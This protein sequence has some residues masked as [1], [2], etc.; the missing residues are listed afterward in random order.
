MSSIRFSKVKLGEPSQDV[1][2]DLDML[3]ADH[4]VL[5]TS[6]QLGT[7]Y[8]DFFSRSSGLAPQLNTF[9]HV[10]PTSNHQAD[11]IVSAQKDPTF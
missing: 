11:G 3:V 9:G 2:M 8:D 10:K 6:S 5:T 7:R 4:H 1:D